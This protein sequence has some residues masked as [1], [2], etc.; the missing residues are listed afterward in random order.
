MTGNH[1][2]RRLLVS[3]ACSASFFWFWILHEADT[4]HKFNDCSCPSQITPRIVRNDTNAG[5]VQ[6]ASLESPVT[7]LD[8]SPSPF[9]YVFYIT[10]EE[11]ACSALIN[12]DRL[13]HVFHTQLR[14]IVLAKPSLES[15][16]LSQFT[17]QNATVIPYE[18][19][20]LA[21]NTDPYYADV[22]LKLV[23]FRLHHYIPSL[24]RVLILDSDQLVL[25]SLD[26]IFSLPAADVAAPRA[27]WRPSGF[28]SAFLLVNLSDRLWN[29]INFALEEIEHG[30]FDM[31]L[32]NNLFNDT[33]LL[34]PG[35]YCTVNSHWEINDVPLWWQG[36]EP[37]RDSMWRPSRPRPPHPDPPPVEI[38]LLREMLSS[39]ADDQDP[40]SQDLSHFS[41]MDLEE[42]AAEHEAVIHQA[43]QER[44][45]RIQETR[46]KDRE[47]RQ[48]RIELDELQERFYRLGDT[49]EEVYKD[50]KVLHYTAYGKPWMY[51]AGGLKHNR[52]YAHALL[53]EQFAIWRQRAGEVC[54]GWAGMDI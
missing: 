27:Y 11:Y 42:F 9:G 20:P 17:A 26:H 21:N 25:Q 40:N 33:V 5:H 37:A 13:R 39:N 4:H 18:P 1:C 8:F 6:G 45:V 47:A 51:P 32:V 29:R 15:E 12:I 44:K 19:P 49:L 34:L 52:P 7:S 23:G 43:N 35:D 14:I 41:R 3:L 16:Y 48:A 28:T 31:D 24:K 53:T 2:F 54:P 38:P 36:E 22:L 30:T 10:Q 46:K 50:V